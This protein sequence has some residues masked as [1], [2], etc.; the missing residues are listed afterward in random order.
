MKLGASD[1]HRSFA[2]ASLSFVLLAWAALPCSAAETAGSTAKKESA[3]AQ[4]ARAEE[5]R[6]ALNEK[7]ADQRTL[8]EYKN[9]VAGYQRVY[10]IT[11]HAAE[12]PDSLQAVAELNT[13]MGDRFGRSY[14]QAAAD[15]Y[16]FLIKE[17]PNSKHAQEATLRLAKLQKDQLGDPNGAT[18]TF[19]DYQRKYPH[20]THK[21]EVQ[22]AL[23]ELC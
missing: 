6:T 12:V 19:Q 11:P 15:T 13:E 8:A 4:F 22:E 3:A 5:L 16:S 18:K 2:S 9:V 23:A 21:R 14:Y 1:F 17:Y 10:L 7:P 20:S